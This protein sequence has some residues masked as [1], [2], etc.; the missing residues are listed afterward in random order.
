MSLTLQM[1]LQLWASPYSCLPLNHKQREIRLIEKVSLSPT[2]TPECILGISK[3]PKVE[4]VHNAVL[5]APDLKNVNDLYIAVSYTW[6]APHPTREIII[7]GATVQVRTNLHAILCALASMNPNKIFCD[8]NGQSMVYISDH[9]I[10]LWIVAY[11]IT[12]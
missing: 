11:S 10:S 2:G 3:L 12:A 6:G 8:G 4:Q 1:A 7:N 9:A 5:P